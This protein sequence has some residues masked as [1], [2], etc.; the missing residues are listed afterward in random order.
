MQH[1]L[2]SVSI[3]LPIILILMFGFISAKRNIFGN[4]ATTISTLSKLVLTITLPPLLFAGTLSISKDQLNNALSLFGALLFS[5][6]LLY[7]ICFFVARSFFKRNITE[8]A[9]AGLAGSFSAGPFYGPALLEPLYG[10]SSSVSISMIAIVINLA[11]IPLATIMIEIDQEKKQAT[12]NKPIHKLLLNSIYHAIIDCPYVWAPLLAII[13]L[14]CGV[15]LPQFMHNTCLLIGKA[16]SGI[17][18]FVAGMTIAVNRFKLTKECISFALIKD[19]GLP[20]MFLITASLFFLEKGTPIFNEGL[21][22]CAMPSGPMII[23]FSNQYK[24]YQ[25]EAA[26]ILAISTFSMIVTVTILIGLLGL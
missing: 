10:N 24:Q 21:L 12:A 17:A 26:S 7:L 14:L 4:N 13:L 22:L 20:A 18:V 6:I 2:Q 15:H 16:T 11:L 9:L 5:N 25:Q 1:L 8:A 23:L 19:I 3:V